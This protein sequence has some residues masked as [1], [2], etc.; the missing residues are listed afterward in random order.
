MG[1]GF[2]DRV[3]FV[4]GRVV[5]AHLRWVLGWLLLCSGGGGI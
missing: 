2:S 1:A 5:V 4:F 3:P